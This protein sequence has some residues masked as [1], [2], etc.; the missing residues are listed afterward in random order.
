[1]PMLWLRHC[2]AISITSLVIFVASLFSFGFFIRSLIPTCII[3]PSYSYS[4]KIGIEWW[5]SCWD[6]EPGKTL[7]WAIPSYRWLL[8]SLIRSVFNMLSNKINMFFGLLLTAPLYVGLIFCLDIGI[9]LSSFVISR[10]RS[11]FLWSFL[12]IVFILM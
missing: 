2:S 6:L 9:L 1:M 8:N 10:R 7:R 5:F 3:A 4:C 11:C 12:V